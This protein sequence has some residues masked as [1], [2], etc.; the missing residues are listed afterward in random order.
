MRRPSHS[1]A[2]PLVIT[3]LALAFSF[4]ISDASQVSA[5]KLAQHSPRVETYAPEGAPVTFYQASLKKEDGRILLN[6]SLANSTNSQLD[7][8][9][10]I[11][12]FL[13]SSAEVKGGQGWTVSM[14]A[15]SS[16]VVEASMELTGDVR[17]A[18]HVLLTVWKANGNSISFTRAISRTLKAYKRSRGLAGFSQGAAEFVKAGAQEIKNTCT[19]SLTEAKEICGCGGIKAFSCNPSN[20][21]YSFE[22]FPK[23]GC[24]GGKP[25]TEESAN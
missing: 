12:L 1:R 11:A 3:A 14:S 4:V 15:A 9:Q 21:Q 7:S 20:G 22:C 25:A 8:V 23:N 16:G 18:D 5:S 13:D 24:D 17:S 10:L 19:A 6:Y 2:C